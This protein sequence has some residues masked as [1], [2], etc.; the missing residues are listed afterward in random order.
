MNLISGTKKDIFVS[1]VL[2]CKDQVE[3]LK[4]KIRPIY[5]TLAKNYVDFEIVI[6]DN[7]SFD[8]TEAYITSLLSKLESIRYIRLSSEV[9]SDVSLS[10]GLENAIGDFV[11]LFD[12]STDPVYVITNVVDK[13]LAESDVVIGVAKQNSSLTYSIIRSIMNR[14]L[15][16]IGYKLPRNATNLRCLSRR[17]VNAV[18]ANG[19]FH[20]KMMVRISNTGFSS[21]TEAYELAQVNEKKV[22]LSGIR[23]T[24]KVMIFN[25]TKPL[26]WM[27]L[28]G[29]FGSFLAF[30]FSLYS[31]IVRMINNHVIEGWTTQI[32]FMSILFMLLFTM[33]AFFGEYL[34]RL[35]D[36]RSEHSDYNII[37][38][39]NSSVMIDSHRVNVLT[40]STPDIVNLVQTGRN[41]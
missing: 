38:E 34:G 40:D 22:L 31:L 2:S 19:R 27:S 6:I 32:I 39:K 4:N 3:D 14:S 37:Y 10:A 7:Y 41:K 23:D 16:L 13:S 1:V 33:L 25:S 12:I 29:I 15:S 30:I 18:T 5:D 11:V 35:L 20:H 26:R 17:A 21:T 36:D 28:L 8:N 24:I 9:S